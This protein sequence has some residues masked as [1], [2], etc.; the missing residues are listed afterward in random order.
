M[1]DWAVSMGDES[2]LNDARSLW[3]R[4]RLATRARSIEVYV[5]H[6]RRWGLRRVPDGASLHEHEAVEVGTACR[7]TIESA[8]AAVHVA[9]IGTDLGRLQH[10]IEN[11]SAAPRTDT[12]S[13]AIEADPPEQRTDHEPSD[14]RFDPDGVRAWMS[15]APRVSSVEL[16]LTTEV[17][18]GPGGWRTLRTRARSSALIGSH[19]QLVAQRGFDVVQLSGEVDESAEFGDPSA[20]LHLAPLAAAPLVMTLVHAAHSFQPW[21]G[22]AAGRGWEIRDDPASTEG[23]AGGTFDDAGFP[24]ALRTLA[25]G[26][27]VVAGLDGPGTYW[28]RSYRDAPVPLP[29][30]IVVGTADA[31]PARPRVVNACRVLPL[32]RENWVL[33]LPGGRSR[34]V[35]T[36]P[37]ELLR[38]VGGTFGSPVATADGV[39]T[40]G[41][42]LEGFF[43]R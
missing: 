7:W 35:R 9:M 42:V 16:G 3:E 34:F 38:S 14:T 41:L 6:A 8:R 40:P 43:P 4:A 13:L 19:G 20:P 29:S 17:L 32:D 30:T 27:R 37:A 22:E 28:R 12:A 39:V 15:G 23:L 26:G 10:V 18:V 36:G 2:H 1:T 11:A 33:E 5:K 31:A 24:T 25:A 21:V